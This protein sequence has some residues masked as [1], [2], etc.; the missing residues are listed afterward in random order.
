[1]LVHLQTGPHVQDESQMLNFT[2]NQNYIF[3]NLT[4]EESDATQD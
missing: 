1:M 3:C 4:T 2:L